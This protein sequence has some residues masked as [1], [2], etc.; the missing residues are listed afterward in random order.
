MK[1][2]QRCGWDTRPLALCQIMAGLL[3]LLFGTE[4]AD[5]AWLIL[6]TKLGQGGVAGLTGARI[7]NS[8]EVEL[9]VLA[10]FGSLA[11]HY[12][13]SGPRCVVRLRLARTAL[14]LGLIVAAL[15]FAHWTALQ[16]YTTP[17]VEPAF[18]GLLGFVLLVFTSFACKFGDRRCRRIALIIGLS[19]LLCAVF[20]SPLETLQS[21][22]IST[23]LGLMCL[24]VMLATP[25]HEILSQGLLASVDTLT[26]WQSKLATPRL[27]THRV[28]AIKRS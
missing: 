9:A 12:V 27:R 6:E 7:V 10:A 14:A 19:V 2:P 23:L 15:A 24:S 26:G 20:F 25:A 11:L 21:A 8:T 16:L 28:D 4:V 17:G 5:T 18:S 13:F 3:A 22:A 1:H